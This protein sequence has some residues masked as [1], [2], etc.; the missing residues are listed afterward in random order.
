MRSLGP[1]LHR[2]PLVTL[3][4]DSDG[5]FPRRAYHFRRASP[6]PIG[7]TQDLRPLRHRLM[8]RTT[9]EADVTSFGDVIPRQIFFRRASV[10]LVE[11]ESKMKV[12]VLYAL[13]VLTVI[14]L[15]Y[16]EDS[17]RILGLLAEFE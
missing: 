17:F 16:A 10:L 4:T 5:I 1:S 11:D 12:S 13:L 3:T 8:K 9:L 7:D 15:T 14:E 2:L 6:T